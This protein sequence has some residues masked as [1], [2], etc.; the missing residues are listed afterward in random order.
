[1]TRPDSNPAAPV[2]ITNSLSVTPGAPWVITLMPVASEPSVYHIPVR[3]DG[4]GHHPTPGSHEQT[5]HH[6]QPQRTAVA[7]QRVKRR[8]PRRGQP[9]DLHVSLAAAGGLNRADQTH[10]LPGTR[11]NAALQSNPAPTA[12]FLHVGEPRPL[13]VERLIPQP[14]TLPVEKLLRE[15]DRAVVG[16]NRVDLLLLRGLL[17]SSRID[18]VEAKCGVRGDLD[19]RRVDAGAGAGLGAIGCVV[20]GSGFVSAQRNALCPAVDARPPDSPSKPEPSCRSQAP[21]CS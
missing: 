15:R 14:H 20:D 4:T 16:D 11:G 9:T 18:R 5:A 12:R 1:M 13:E 7:A 21:C 10:H 8:W 17:V 2:T 19:R 3:A 6:R